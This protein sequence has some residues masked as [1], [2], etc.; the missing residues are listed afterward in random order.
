MTLSNLNSV[1]Q[2][3]WWSCTEKLHTEIFNVRYKLASF[4][5]F[6]TSV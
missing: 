4:D 6:Y 3:W 5:N 1:F 2:Y